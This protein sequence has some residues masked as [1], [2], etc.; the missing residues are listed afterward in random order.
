MIITGALQEYRDILSIGFSSTNFVIGLNSTDIQ[1]AVLYS[2][3]IE[4]PGVMLDLVP[5]CPEYVNFDLPWITK[6]TNRGTTTSLL[7]LLISM[8]PDIYTN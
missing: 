5:W 3:V 7:N 1:L 2:R 4:A 6:R 8:L